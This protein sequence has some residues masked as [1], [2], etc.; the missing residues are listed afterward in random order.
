[1]KTR[2]MSWHEFV[3]SEKRAMRIFR[4]VIF[5]LA[6]WM[7]FASTY[8]YYLQV[9]HYKLALGHLGSILFLQTFFLVLIHL[10]AC[11]YFIYILFPRYLL[12][13]KYFLLSA[14]TIVLAIF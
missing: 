5:W 3:F 11:Y 2:S 10:A 12:T 8:S 7:Y 6:W 13:R 4:H 1:M 9:G 14:G